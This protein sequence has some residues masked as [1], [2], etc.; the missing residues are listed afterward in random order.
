MKISTRLLAVA[1]GATA[2]SAGCFSGSYALATA[3]DSGST[4]IISREL[5]WDDSTSLSLGVRCV[6][7][8]V[9][10]NGPGKVVAR[11]PHRSISTLMVDNGHIHDQLLRTGATLELTVFAPAI[12][13]FHL[14]GGSRLSIEGYDQ[15]HLH[16]STEGSA[17]IDA[18]GR[19]DTV[20]IEMQGKGVINLSRFKMD[21]AAANI[22]GMST[23]VLAPSQGADLK[24]RNFASAVLLTR[25]PVVTTALADSGRVVDA[26]GY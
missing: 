17:F 20:T 14:N 8:Y 25:P 18:V 21:S 4:E 11:G 19:A 24:V 13:R 26:A 16:L 23:L 6:V 5:S 12:S 22:G 3:N 15:R 10:Q 9:Q 2:I 1:V 7:R